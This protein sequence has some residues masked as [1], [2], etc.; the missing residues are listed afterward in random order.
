MEMS[1]EKYM[2]TILNKQ[3]GTIKSLDSTWR[4]TPFDILRI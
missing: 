3:K 4:K 1:T 2:L